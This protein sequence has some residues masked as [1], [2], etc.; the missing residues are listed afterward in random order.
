MESQKNLIDIILV[1][2][3]RFV[4]NLSQSLIKIAEAMHQNQD[5]KIHLNTEG[6]SIEQLTYRIEDNLLNL[7]ELMCDKN[8][9]DPARIEIITGNLIEDYKGKFLVRKKNTIKGWFYGEHLAKIELD[10]VKKFEYLY[11]NFVSNSTYPRLL[12]GSYLHQNYRDKTLQT[13]RRNPRDPGQA[14]DLD[15]DKL[16]FECADPE[17]LTQIASFINHLP[18]ELEQGL[19]EHPMTNISAGEDGDAINR[20]ILSWYNKFFCDVVTETF[21]SGT[22]FFPTEKITRPLL[23]KNPFIVHGPIGYLKHLRSLG[24]KTFS[25]YWSEDYDHL[26]GYS[27]CKEMYNVICHI[28][29]MDVDSVYQDMLPILQ[30]NRE[31]LL[32]LTDDQTTKF[33]KDN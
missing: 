28:S 20:N 32:S 33:M 4:H 7:L 17:V 27:R 14:V 6:P 24:F 25:K 10:D 2:S 12:L 21:F 15:L 1:V 13:F 18:L 22:T 9:Y 30:H 16:M 8:R 23:C 5:I 3:D 31:H 19:K 29:K 11:G 26:Q